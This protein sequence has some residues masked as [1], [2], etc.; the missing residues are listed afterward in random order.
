MLLNEG[1]MSL[2]IFISEIEVHIYIGQTLLMMLM[3]ANKISTMHAEEL[4][5]IYSTAILLSVRDGQ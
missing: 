1:V 2:K 5:N 3:D 4:M